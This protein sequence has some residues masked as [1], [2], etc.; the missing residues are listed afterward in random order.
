MCDAVSSFYRT[1][2]DFLT[3]RNLL[4]IDQ[5]TLAVLVF[6]SAAFFYLDRIFLFP[7]LNPSNRVLFISPTLDSTPKIKKQFIT[8]PVSFHPGFS[9]PV[10]RSTPSHNVD[11][12]TFGR[13]NRLGPSG[14]SSYN[15]RLTGWGSK[16]LSDSPERERGFK[17]VYNSINRC[18][19]AAEL[20]RKT[21]GEKMIAEG[22]DCI[23][24]SCR[25]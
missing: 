5:S 19:R 22:D 25:Q 21:G 9:S 3:G 1:R 18:G 13:N 12:W 4:E 24:S 17:R 10:M 11:W 15:I 14:T 7:W 2:S 6:P 20:G 8:L 16:S 23:R